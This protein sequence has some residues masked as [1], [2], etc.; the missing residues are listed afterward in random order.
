MDQL[1]LLKDYFAKLGSVVIAYSSGV[2]STFLLKVAHDVLGDNAIAVTAVAS[3]FP[4]WEQDES[5]Q[6]CEQEGIKHIHCE[7]DPLSIP[8]FAENPP[9]RCYLCKKTIFQN[10]ITE[11]EQ[12]GIHVVVEGTNA[13]DLSDYRPGMRAI[14]ELGI[15][16][17]LKELGFTKEMIRKYSKELG[18]AT[19][20]KPSYACLASRF[21]Y[22]ES[23]TREK[24]SMVNQAEQ[25]L[26]SLGFQ[27]MRVRIHGQIARIEVP[28]ERFKDIM[29]E[30]VRIKI[31]KNLKQL[32][33]KYVALDMTGYRTGS[34]N[35]VLDLKSIR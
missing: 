22:G 1:Q 16:S 24:L 34:M 19:W 14:A 10:I 23:I 33:F 12:L 21:A 13:D 11:A 31:E 9:D 17:P 25:L 3:I 27:Q 20:E 26:I 28:Q 30:S 32:G 6:F 18:L 8:G 4:E 5:N 15:A 2:D 35:E 7:I 29:E